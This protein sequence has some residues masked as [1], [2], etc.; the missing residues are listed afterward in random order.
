[1]KDFSELIEEKFG[2]ETVIP[3]KGDNFLMS[4]K[5]VIEESEDPEVKYSFKRLAVIEMMETLKEEF[6]ELD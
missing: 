5:N 2:I 3:A 6:D 1:M 4:A